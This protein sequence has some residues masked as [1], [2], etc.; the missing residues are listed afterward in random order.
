VSDEKN[1]TAQ[2][3]RPAHH[4]VTLPGFMLKEDTGLGTAIKYMTKAMG[5]TPCEGCEA[6]AAVLDRW[7]QFTPSTHKR[8]K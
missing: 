4:T 7:V 1:E 5:I 2:E 8:H 6:R 3:R